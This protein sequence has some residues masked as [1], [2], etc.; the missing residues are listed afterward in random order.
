MKEKIFYLCNTY[1]C[2]PGA[3]LL[4]QRATAHPTER[5]PFHCAVSNTKVKD[6]PV[7]KC[8]PGYVKKY[9]KPIVLDKRVGTY[10]EKVIVKDWNQ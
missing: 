4:C 9:G 10:S 3:N 5:T 2:V 8:P 1:N 6:I 7:K